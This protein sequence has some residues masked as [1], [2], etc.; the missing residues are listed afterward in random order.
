MKKNLKILFFL[1]LAGFSLTAQELLFDNG[2][3]INFT[4][5]PDLSVQQNVTLGMTTFG[6]ST[7]ETGSGI[8]IPTQLAD[9]VTPV[10]DNWQVS[11][12]SLFAYTPN[13]PISNS[14]IGKVVLRVWEGDPRDGGEIIWGDFTTNRFT[15]TQWAGAFRVQE[16]DPT[17]FDNAVAVVTLQT[18]GLVLNEGV[19]YWFNWRISLRNDTTY[20]FGPYAPPVSIFDQPTTGNGIRFRNDEWQELIDTG[21]GAPQGLPF[22]LFGSTTLGVDDNAL[23][24]QI[25]FYPNPSTGNVTINN[26]TNEE[27]SGIEVYNILGAKMLTFTSAQIVA[28]N[29]LDLSLLNTGSYL[30][31]FITPKGT[32][33]KKLIKN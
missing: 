22:L 27:L 13:A 15:N 21:S 33:V 30:I 4:G 7:D 32:L 20:I 8:G 29:E 2:S 6:Y 9:D 11:T 1:L 10:G 25:D 14:E 31:K 17:D 16:S 5:D 12:M 19:T 3:V 24:N 23:V 26:K 18:P 28:S